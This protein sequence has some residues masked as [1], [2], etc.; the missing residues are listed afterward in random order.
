MIPGRQCLGVAVRLMTFGDGLDIP[1]LETFKQPPE[2]AITVTH[3][4]PF[5]CFD[6]PE[7]YRYSKRSRTSTVT[8]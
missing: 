4:R 7:R 1:P 8:C 2:D 5:L 6:N 3:V